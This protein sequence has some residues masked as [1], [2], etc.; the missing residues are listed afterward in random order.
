MI[1]SKITIS[2]QYLVEV[3]KKKSFIINGKLVIPL[4]QAIGWLIVPSGHKVYLR[5]ENN[6]LRLMAYDYKGNR[7]PN[8]EDTT[9]LNLQNPEISHL[10]LPKKSICQAAQEWLPQIEN[11]LMVKIKGELGKN[12]L[13]KSNFVNLY[14]GINPKDQKVYG[15]LVLNS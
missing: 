9:T 12:E 2:H 10:I 15:L 1:I 11:R 13:L 8:Q 6:G 4:K 3:E 14:V 5:Q 7:L